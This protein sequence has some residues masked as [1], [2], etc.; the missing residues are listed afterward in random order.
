[1][2]LNK[3]VAG[4]EEAVRDIR[5]GATIMVGGFGLCGIPENLIAALVTKGVKNLTTMSNNA[6]VDNFG[7][8]LL[9]QS[10]QVRKHVGTFWEVDADIVAMR[11][12]DDVPG[13][14]GI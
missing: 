12:G 5:D 3:V 11:H 14:A 6:G 10:K 7:I 8:G 2:P 13:L 4:A 9:L 1:M